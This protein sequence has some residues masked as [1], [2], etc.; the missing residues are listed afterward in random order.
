MK[1]GVKHTNNVLTSPSV[2]DGSTTVKTNTENG[3]SVLGKNHSVI[4]NADVNGD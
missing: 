2:D 3:S 1:K 4:D